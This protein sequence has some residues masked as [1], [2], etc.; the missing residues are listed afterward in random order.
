MSLKGENMKKHLSVLV[1]ILIMFGVA[2][3]ANAL[4]ITFDDLETPGNGVV[5][6]PSYSD[7]GFQFTSSFTS[8]V[9][10]G[11]W[12]QSSPDYNTSAALAN[13]WEGETTTLRA[14]SNALFT[15]NSIDLDTLF[16]DNGPSPVA[17][18]GYDSS[19]TQVAYQQ[20]TLT[21]DGWITLN[22]S[23]DFTNLAYVTFDQNREFHHF[24]NVT[25]NAINAVPE[26]ATMLLLGS[27]L[28]G[29][30]VLRKK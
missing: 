3:V 7:Q 16:A 22:F 18:Y 29:L 4:I 24:D 28:L 15:L 5:E 30:V 19:N 2:G 12:E 8:P 6:I 25:I 23:S 13:A 20:I 21:S 11:Y 1:I 10:F 26:P 17:F 14:T 9:A 27:G